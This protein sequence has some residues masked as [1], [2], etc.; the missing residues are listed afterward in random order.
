MK[1][2]EIDLVKERLHVNG[3]GPLRKL[4]YQRNGLPKQ[5]LVSN[6]N[7]LK[8]LDID[9]VGTNSLETKGIIALLGAALA[10]LR[11]QAKDAGLAWI[12][13]EQTTPHGRFAR[14]GFIDDIDKIDENAT[15]YEK[16]ADQTKAI[17]EKTSTIS[18]QYKR[19]I[20]ARNK[21]ID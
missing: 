5:G 12:D 15:K 1:E 11:K 7:I 19:A 13:W 17:A 21:K 2:S 3:K 18:K 20:G 10:Y 14:H 9:V 8:K 4:F 6:E 16:R